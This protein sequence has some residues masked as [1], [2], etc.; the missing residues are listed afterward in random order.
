MRV[1]VVYLV[2]I[3]LAAL[4]DGCMD[5]GMKMVGHSTEALS[6]L[7]LLILPF[8]HRYRDGWGWY[9]LAYIC[10]RIGMFD[11]IYNVTRGLPLTYHGVTSLWDALLGWFNPPMWAELF[12]RAIFLFTGVMIPLQNIRDGKSNT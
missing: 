4:A 12:G 7:A 3:V 8:I 2:S 5:G 1:L 11:L 10:L 6:V 9:L